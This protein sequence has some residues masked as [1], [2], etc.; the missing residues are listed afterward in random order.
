MP[1]KKVS[2]S[3]NCIQGTKMQYEND[4][5]KMQQTISPLDH[6]QSID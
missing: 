4:G 1:I 6:T 2:K 5:N 3:T